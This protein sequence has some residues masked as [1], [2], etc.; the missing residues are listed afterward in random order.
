MSENIFE[1]KNVTKRFRDVKALDDVSFNGTAGKVIALLGE[2]GAGKT[3]AINV[4]LGS[5]GN[6]N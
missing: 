6:D 1:L 4:L 5:L 3:T 2:N